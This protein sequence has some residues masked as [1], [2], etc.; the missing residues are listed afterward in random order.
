MLH[1]SRSNDILSCPESP[2]GRRA[3]VSFLMG[4][5]RGERDGL[6]AASDYTSARS[7]SLWDAPSCF[8]TMRRP[9]VII[10]DTCAMMIS[11]CSSSDDRQRIAACRSRTR[12]PDIVTEGEGRC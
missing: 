9:A 3:W 10:G 8:E 4:I 6:V 2:D 7:S 12:S 11:L 1:F 5:C